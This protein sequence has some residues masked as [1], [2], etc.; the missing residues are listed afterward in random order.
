MGHRRSGD[1]TCRGRP[2]S[3]GPRSHV[4]SRGLRARQRRCRRRGGDRRGRQGAG[5]TRRCARVRTSA[6]TWSSAAG[7]TWAPACRSATT[8]RSRTTRSSTSRRSSRTASSS[9][10]PSVLTNDHFPPARHQRRRQRPSRAHD[11]EPVGVTIVEGAS[12]GASATC[13]APVTIGR[14]ALVGSGAVVVKDVPDFALVVGSPGPPRRLGRQG[15]RPPR[16]GR[17]GRVDLPADGRAL[18]RERRHA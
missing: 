16:R 13:V 12:I 7:P 9:A 10:R 5:T 6:A 15:R 3:K 2:P 4:Q 18:H 11:W 8:A 14:W 1:Y 17:R